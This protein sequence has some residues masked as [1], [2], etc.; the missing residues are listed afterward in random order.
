MQ[1]L[2]NAYTYLYTE[3]RK[4]KFASYGN[5]LN[6]TLGKIWN[7]TNYINFRQRVEKFEFPD[8]TLCD[9]C[10]DRLTNDTDC[11]YNTF[12]TCGACLWAQG[13]ARCP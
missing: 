6:N 11:M 7:N 5:V 10:D 1:L 9:G 4:I 2:R 8:C 12:P 13:I 3:K